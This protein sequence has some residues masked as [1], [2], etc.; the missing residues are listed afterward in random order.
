MRLR[1]LMQMTVATMVVIH[2]P[3]VQADET[4]DQYLE[5]LEDL[6]QLMT[7]GMDRQ[8]EI[9]LASLR[10]PDCFEP[11]F[12]QS[13]KMVRRLKKL[14]EA[15]SCK[16]DIEILDDLNTDMSHL[17]ILRSCAKLLEAH[18]ERAMAI[19]DPNETAECIEHVYRLINHVGPDS[20]ISSLVSV[21]ILDMGDE[22]LEEAESRSLISQQGAEKILRAIRVLDL[23]DPT[24]F[25]KGL[26]SEQRMTRSM[27][28]EVID[29]VS[30]EYQMVI[31]KELARYW[32]AVFELWSQREAVSTAKRIRELD[33]AIEAGDYG[34]F[35]KLV[36]ISMETA[37]SRILESNRALADRISSLESTVAGD[38]VQAEMTNAAV[39]YARAL[40]LIHTHDDWR[41]EL[42]IRERIWGLLDA[43]ASID[44]CRFPNPEDLSLEMEQRILLWAAPVIPWWLS[45]LDAVIGSLLEH[46]DAST[47]EVDL[48]TSV[49][50]I[51]MAARMVSHLCADP[52]IASSIVAAGRTGQILDL[53]S[54]MLETG[55]PPA[56]AQGL[57]ESLRTIPTSDPFG[58]RQATQRTELRLSMHLEELARQDVLS[59]Q[60]ITPDPMDLL[61]ATAWIRD[62]PPPSNEEAGFTVECQW[63]D[64]AAAE[65]CAPLVQSAIESAAKDGRQAAEAWEMDVPLAIDRT[66]DICELDI[67][68][69]I[70]GTRAR[71][72]GVRRELRN[73]ILQSSSTE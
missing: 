56:D 19:K 22:L 63:P 1:Q 37:F 24:R 23:E 73:R 9:L 28:Q 14:L 52:N 64:G 48:E 29:Q 55:I 70:D 34:Q 41:S 46:D 43:A 18:A 10:P 53:I 6:D 51:Q 67:D 44:D 7:E 45:G 16:W 33:D 65:A 25:T 11:L 13:S 12:D 32:Q 57:L 39:L 4:A 3:F 26:Q 35:V 49:T 47:P 66:M 5:M 69:L 21:S 58:I 38:P 50:N 71:L 40:E 62:L 2:S 31:K 72:L 17:S 59:E 8:G 30:E 42:A 15:E 60:S 54:S 27:M 36:G 20:L 61:Y 68:V